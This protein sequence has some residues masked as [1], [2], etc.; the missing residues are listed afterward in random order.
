LLRWWRSFIMVPRE[1]DG[2]SMAK[3]HLPLLP[4]ELM[5]VELADDTAALACVDC[6]AIGLAQRSRTAL[7]AADQRRSRRRVRRQGTADDR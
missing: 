6:D 1:S 7:R 2:T 3:L 4:G 5:R